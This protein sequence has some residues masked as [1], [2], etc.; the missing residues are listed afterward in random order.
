MSYLV[1]L[2]EFLVGRPCSGTCGK[3]MRIKDAVRVGNTYRVRWECK[4]KGITE[5]FNV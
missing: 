4:C 3:R 5:I 1:R 2:W